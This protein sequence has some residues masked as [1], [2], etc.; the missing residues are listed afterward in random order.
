MR[1]EIVQRILDNTKPIIKKKI[2]L[3]ADL[4]VSINDY[5]EHNDINLKNKPY[6]QSL[7]SNDLFNIT[8][9]S[10]EHI[11]H[12]EIELGISLLKSISL[13]LNIDSTKQLKIDDYITIDDGKSKLIYG[14]VIKLSIDEVC[15]IFEDEVKWFQIN[16][17]TIKKLNK[18]E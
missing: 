5:I 15:I 17:N 1:S 4:W 14:N 7:L 10:L 11:L 3:E 6:T 9:L 18:Y 2:S 16:K 8:K 13:E 12:I